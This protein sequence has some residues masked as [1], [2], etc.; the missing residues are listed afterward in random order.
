MDQFLTARAGTV[1]ALLVACLPAPAIGQAICS[2]PHSSPTLT[3]SGA[4]RTLPAGAGWVQ[5]SVS[6]QRA[7]EAFNPLGERQPLIGGSS[8]DTRSLF[9]TA[10][11]GLT[12]GVE[13]WG[14]LPA[15]RLTVS[16]SAG[17]SEG[18]GVGD[19]RGAVRVSPAVVGWTVP[20][21]LRLGV[22]LP[23]SDFPVDPRLIPLTEGQRDVE[24]SVEA[25]W[26]GTERPLYVVGWVGYRWRAANEV[27]GFEPGDE[28]FLHAAVG[29][30]AGPLTFELGLDALWGAAPVEQG[31]TLEGDRRRLVQILPT[32]GS[33]VG[34][35]RLEVT[36]PVSI[37]GRNLPAAVGI[38]IGYRTAWGL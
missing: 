10:A 38:S 14:Q 34:P 37:A 17:R 7:T 12:E 1:L 6:G 19:I 21:A 23:G 26:S 24:A 28:R 15:H 11:Y 27:A 18:S 13:V 2:A 35:G 16:G 30:W 25:G 5:L 31:L 9:L 29:G 33:E 3:Q 4:I 32:V 20:V 22:K 8:F 36:A